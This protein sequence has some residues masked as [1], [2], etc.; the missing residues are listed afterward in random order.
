MAEL[1]KR[2]GEREEGP[3]PSK[4]RRLGQASILCMRELFRTVVN[5]GD[6]SEDK[7]ILLQNAGVLLSQVDGK[8]WV[9]FPDN[10]GELKELTPQQL[11][12]LRPF[13]ND[14][15][16]ELKK[17]EAQLL[18][19]EATGSEHVDCL[20]L[21]KVP[22]A[23]GITARELIACCSPDEELQFST[24]RRWI[25]VIIRVLPSK[26]M[27]KS[28]VRELLNY[29]YIQGFSP[30]AASPTA[31]P[32]KRVGPFTRFSQTFPGTRFVLSGLLVVGG[33]LRRL[34]MSCQAVAV[35]V[36]GL[37]AAA[38]VSVAAA[39]AAGMAKLMCLLPFGHDPIWPLARL[40]V[41]VLLQ[42][43]MKKLLEMIVLIARLRVVLCLARCNNL[44][45]YLF[46]PFVF[47][48]QK[49]LGWNEGSWL[50]GCSCDSSKGLSL[51]SWCP[52][53]AAEGLLALVKALRCVPQ[54]PG[55]GGLA[56][57]VDPLADAASYVEPALVFVSDLIFSVGF[58]EGLALIVR[59]IDRRAHHKLV[60][61]S[62]NVGRMIRE[63][64]SGPASENVQEIV[65]S[66]ATPRIADSPQP[67]PGWS[68]DGDWN[69][70]DSAE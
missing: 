8:T 67:L 66:E 39:L 2:P 11:A 58:A 16:E 30:E 13:F 42:G 43:Q 59:S 35:T 9:S 22:W 65:H 52:V 46:F 57:F 49:V 55:L 6:I 3:R 1:R 21:T 69:L 62:L 27:I 50:L 41:A 25:E 5:D 14:V 26:Y 56:V 63:G 18:C 61:M 38:V 34:G 24:R 20:E 48:A 36:A 51:L 70:F 15:A 23:D 64:P 47:L 7:R 60:W 10:Q 19:D 68:E 32:A 28:R 40:F 17:Q 54:V 4:R 45:G 12:K 37:V 44:F 53:R 33:G 29:Y 31:A